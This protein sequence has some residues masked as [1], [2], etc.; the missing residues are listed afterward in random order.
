MF[1][2]SRVPT[3]RQPQ[4]DVADDRITSLDILG[5]YKTGMEIG[6]ITAQSGAQTTSLQSAG[7]VLLRA[8]LGTI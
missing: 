2:G 3:S 4:H 5:R 7:S 1:T 8:L 6:L